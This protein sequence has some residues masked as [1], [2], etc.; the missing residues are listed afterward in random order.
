MKGTT[1]EEYLYSLQGSSCP[2]F[3]FSFSFLPQGHSVH[4]EPTVVE[5]SGFHRY[6]ETSSILSHPQEYFQDIMNRLCISVARISL[7]PNEWHLYKELLLFLGCSKAFSL[8]VGWT[9]RLTVTWFMLRCQSLNRYQRT[10]YKN[11]RRAKLYVSSVPSEG[12]RIA[13]LLEGDIHLRKEW[14]SP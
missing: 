8:A 12:K 9:G 13:G 14:S 10:L 3:L 11:T 1:E 4:V 7:R 5:S 2:I 6:S